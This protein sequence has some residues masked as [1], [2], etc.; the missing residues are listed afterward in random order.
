[1]GIASNNSTPQPTSGA[2]TPGY[3]YLWPKRN[4][5]YKQLFILGRIA[6]WIIY[7]AYVNEEE[8]MTME[9]IAFD[10]DLPLEAVQEA[11]AYYESNPPDMLEDFRREDARA[12]AIGLDDP[13]YKL[14]PQPK[15]LSPEERAA[16]RRE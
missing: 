1:M 9:E 10:R 15:N 5:V 7:G 11:I 14:N 2:G 13:G 4:S 12:Q 3:K 8:P 16:I 6:P